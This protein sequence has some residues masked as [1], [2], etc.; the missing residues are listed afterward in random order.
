MAEAQPAEFT[1]FWKTCLVRWMVS[2]CRTF[3]ASA[4]FSSLFPSGFDLGPCR[5]PFW[6]PSKARP[7]ASPPD[8]S[9]P[10]AQEPPGGFQDAIVASSGPDFR[11]LHRASA[12]RAQQPVD[13]LCFARHVS[14]VGLL[15][16]HPAP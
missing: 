9:G 1:L 15:L 8:H 7:G 12:I 11:G 10:G 14:C 6:R 4:P 13:F 3:P 16:L 2:L 5:G